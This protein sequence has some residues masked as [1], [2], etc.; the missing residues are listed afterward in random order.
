MLLSS[1]PETMKILCLIYI[2]KPIP[3]KEGGLAALTDAVEGKQGSEE[4]E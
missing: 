3:V 1:S 4:L 2:Q